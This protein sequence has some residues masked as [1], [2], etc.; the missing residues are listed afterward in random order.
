MYFWE[1][2]EKVSRIEEELKIGDMITPELASALDIKVWLMGNN[3]LKEKDLKLR[4]NDFYE[5]GVLKYPG[6]SV[7]ASF[8]P[9]GDVL[10]FNRVVKAMMDRPRRREDRLWEA[11]VETLNR[12]HFL[13]FWAPTRSCPLHLRL[14]HRR[15]LDN[16]DAGQL[17]ERD[18]RPFVRCFTQ[19]AR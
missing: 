14:V 11:D 15:H 5:L 16:P 18:L 10:D 17:D 6:K 9:G 19:I 4:E 8:Y 3:R 2:R 7:H 1:Y 12:R 13:T